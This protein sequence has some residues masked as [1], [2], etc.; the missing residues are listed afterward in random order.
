MVQN[1]SLTTDNR[2]AT[3]KSSSATVYIQTK[4]VLYEAKQYTL[5]MNHVWKQGWGKT[6]SSFTGKQCSHVTWIQKKRYTKY[7]LHQRS[8]NYKTLMVKLQTMECFLQLFSVI[9]KNCSKC[10][11]RTWKTHRFIIVVNKAEY[12]GTKTRVTMWSISGRKTCPQPLLPH[13]E[14]WC[15]SPRTSSKWRKRAMESRAHHTKKRPNKNET[16]KQE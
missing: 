5:S 7:E 9:V 13:P 8:K 6:R 2:E 11:D 4:Y 10:E 3:W 15:R 16:S 14:S 1:L 12:T